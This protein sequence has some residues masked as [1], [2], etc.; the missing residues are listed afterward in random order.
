LAGASSAGAVTGAIT[1]NTAIA[2]IMRHAL[3]TLIGTNRVNAHNRRGP[4][5]R[6]IT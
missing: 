5:I 3:R 2:A 4:F 1:A 6:S